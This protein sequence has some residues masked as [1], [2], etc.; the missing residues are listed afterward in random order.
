[1]AAIGI[2]YKKEGAG[3]SAHL[4]LSSR[5]LN[6]NALVVGATSTRRI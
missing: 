3:H 1:M 6:P 4:L 5:L 2:K